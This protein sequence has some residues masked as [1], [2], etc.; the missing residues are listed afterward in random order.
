MEVKSF[1]YELKDGKQYEFCERAKEDIDYSHV[2]ALIRKQKIAEAYELIPKDDQALRDA[3]IMD[4]F[5]KAYTMLDVSIYISSHPDEI[6]KL[7]YYSFK[8]KNN[9]LYEVFAELI[10]DVMAKKLLN[11]LSELEKDDNGIPD[12]DV[13]KA[14]GINKT[15]LVKINKTQPHVYQWLKTNVKKKKEQQ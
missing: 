9:L 1:F 15:Q 4:Q 14:L 10:D 8:I 12:D 13:C 2:Q 6:K 11:M 7:I 5:N 3:L